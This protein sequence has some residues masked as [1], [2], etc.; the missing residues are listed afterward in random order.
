MG[1]AGEIPAIRDTLAR[2]EKPGDGDGDAS[3]P[4]T[5][6]TSFTPAKETRPLGASGRRAGC[7]TGKQLQNG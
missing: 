1:D 4:T 5:G 7:G 6:R 2:M 3:L